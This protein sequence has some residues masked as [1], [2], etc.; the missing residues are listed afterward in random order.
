[1]TDDRARGARNGALVPLR[2]VEGIPAEMSDEALVAACAVGDAAALGALYDRHQPGLWTFLSRVLAVGATEVDDLVQAT[3]MSVYRAATRFQARAGV[4]TWLFAIGANLAKN[5]LRSEIRR[6]RALDLLARA[7]AG[8]DPGPD[9]S[10]ERRQML[11]R[12]SFA[13]AALPHDLRVA[14]LLCDIEEIAGR[15]AASALGIPEGTL[16]RHV[17]EARRALRA[18]VER[19]GP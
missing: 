2:R 1:M 7:P 14:Y 13:L 10:A 8:R 6:R 16:W 19:D 12:V 3:F 17:H 18:A 4:R 9:H 15:D 11:E 5:H